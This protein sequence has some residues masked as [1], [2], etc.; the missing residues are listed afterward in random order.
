MPL[1]A[2]VVNPH[3]AS[4]S[5]K[6]RIAAV[7]KEDAMD[8]RSAADRRTRELEEAG[9]DGVILE[10]SEG[11]WEVLVFDPA[12]VKS[13]FNRGTWDPGDPGVGR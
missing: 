6:K 4:L 10:H 11:W 2:R 13:V 8:G 7:S 12:G 3:Y 9:H 1:F 5:E